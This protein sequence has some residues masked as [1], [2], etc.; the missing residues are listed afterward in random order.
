MT[1]KSTT[2]ASRRVKLSGKEWTPSVGQLGGVNFLTETN[3]AALWADP[4]AGK[5][6]MTL[7]AFA[8]LQDA[9]LAR[10]MLVLC[11][12]RVGQLVWRQE[13]NK[14][15]HLRHLKIV[16]CHGPKKDQLIDGEG[17]V[18]LVNYEG[19]K[20]LAR[21]Y[22]GKRMPFDIL[23]ADELT[24]MKNSRAPRFKLLKPFLS[25]FRRI[26]G[27]TGTPAPNGYLD[28]F[29]QYLFLDQGATLGRYFSHYR[30]MYF[31]PGYDGFTYT[32]RHGGAD[33]IHKRID[34]ITH[35]ISY[36]DLP[37]LIDDPI[38]IEMEGEALKTYRQMRD[39]QL[40]E[41]E[42]K[43]ITGA[44][45]AAVYGKLKQMAN[46]AVYTTPDPDAPIKR[47][48]REW[49]HVHDLKLKAIAEL[50]DQLQGT[51][52][53]VAY[54][55][56]HDLDRL[57]ATFGED[58]PYLGAGVNER[59]AADIQDAW[60]RGELPILLCHPASVG[61][62]L[63]LQEGG[64]A[65]LCWFSADFDL[66]LYDQFKRRIWRKGNDSAHVFNHR[67]IVK[68]TIDEL[69]FAAL[70]DKDVTQARLLQS[71]RQVLELETSADEETTA[72]S[73]GAT[74][75]IKPRM[76]TRAA[77][78]GGVKEAKVPAKAGARGWARP[79]T[80]E[81]DDEDEAT[82]SGFART[83]T[84]QARIVSK[85]KGAPE[86]ET[87]EETEEEAEEEAEEAT[88]ARKMFSRSIRGALQGDTE[89]DDTGDDETPPVTPTKAAKAPTQKIIA[90]GIKSDPNSNSVLRADVSSEGAVV[91]VNFHGSPEAIR[92][93]MRQLL[94]E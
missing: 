9:G 65:H 87:E 75:S 58:T 52:L 27:L 62:G 44:N 1:W 16:L 85:L 91:S 41:L 89:E 48:K 47:G 38:Y 26:W 45:A 59:E 19:I 28:L 15:E 51:P 79:A 90:G 53:L 6:S 49:V 50:V 83:R 74:M 30:D 25:H 81:A 46:G 57:R 80:A 37:D 69:V 66:E 34:G 14:W 93:A 61:H 32:L 13:G 84:Q 2:A 70:E 68:G 29:G 17:D 76:P 8:D 60:N 72:D 67:L 54:Q 11:P 71:V 56:H 3:T 10:K 82:G 55:Y 21:K 64:A 4:G 92:I 94:G 18:F 36:T 7:T 39:A 63:N 33:D 42:G 73:K 86:E 88:P 77:L 43:T 78:E 24:K 40:V 12:L 31:T 23:C 20:W 5:T 35:R 22:K